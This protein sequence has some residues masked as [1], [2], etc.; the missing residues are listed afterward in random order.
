MPDPSKY[1][2]RVNHPNFESVYNTTYKHGKI[3]EFRVVST[4]PYLCDDFCK[5]KIE[6][7]EKTGFLPFY[8]QQKPLHWDR[9]VAPA[10]TAGDWHDDWKRGDPVEFARASIQ[11]ACLS[12]RGDDDVIVMF[13]KDEPFAVIGHNDRYPRIGEDVLRIY[14]PHKRFDEFETYWSC[15]NT[16]EFDNVY[17]GIE[18]PELPVE[19]E[20]ISSKSDS[21]T[22][23]QTWIDVGS[24]CDTGPSDPHVTYI[25]TMSWDCN[26]YTW[27][28][29]VG[30]VAY[31]ISILSTKATHGTVD[32]TSKNCP[33][34]W[35]MDGEYWVCHT[36]DSY[37]P[38]PLVEHFAGISITANPYSDDWLKR[39]KSASSSMS[40]S[41]VHTL[42]KTK[43]VEQ[44]PNAL[45][46]Y[47]DYG[48]D[49]FTSSYE[50]TYQTQSSN[51]LTSIMRNY[52]F[53]KSTLDDEI[54]GL[55]ADSIKIYRKPHTL[56]EIKK[57]LP[58]ED[59]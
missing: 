32:A 6:K 11:Q 58:E 16:D 25:A 23:S 31:V 22:E 33:K 14:S 48:I 44:N 34:C 41:A 28:A 50:G 59:D 18:V 20:L 13:N 38:D 53:A 1:N 29:S 43:Y 21:I 51:Y 35:I 52:S 49:D 17:S 2:L 26:L 15:Q 19:C 8:Y 55:P 9:V 36:F 57:Y 46:I 7:G 4:D 3:S 10:R 30:P 40:P 27:V 39:V 47:A 45:Y 56:E 37:T 24:V 54:R 12:F 5:V 42:L